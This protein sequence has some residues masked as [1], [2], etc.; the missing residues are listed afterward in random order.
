M[1]N[2]LA[3]DT[4]LTAVADAIRTKGGTSASLAFPAGFVSAIADI[5]TGGGSTEPKQIN[6]VNFFDYDG[7][8]VY[9]Y[10]AA[11]FLA[12]DAL[13]QLPSHTGLTAQGWNWTLADAKTQVQTMGLCD[14]GVN[15]ITSDGKTRLYCRFLDSCLSLYI[16]LGV[17]GT[18][19][20]DWG[21][22][23][24]PSTLTGTS[25]TAVVRTPHVYASAGN[26]VVTITVESGSFAIIGN[27]TASGYSY[28]FN[29]LDA[30]PDRNSMPYLAAVSK[31]ELG[32]NAKIGAG[33]CIKLGIESITIPQGQTGFKCMFSNVYALKH[34]NLPQGFNA[35]SAVNPTTYPYLKTISL[36]RSCTKGLMLDYGYSLVRV[37]LP[38]EA[39]ALGSQMFRN[40]YA[41]REFVIPP[42]ITSIPSY[43]NSSGSLAKLT[44]PASVTS[45][46]TNAFNS[47]TNLQELHFKS[48]TP[49]TAA[50]TNS[51]GLSTKVTIYVPAGTLS[52][53]TS[54]TNYPSAST[55]TYVEE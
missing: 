3:T 13:P 46:A 50:N 44:I 28:L 41:L 4:D 52:D 10:K 48:T 21:D 19:S 39:T 36:P 8:I 53:Y 55:Y 5:P 16:G 12:L 2:Y 32:Q 47:C 7:T 40:S 18:V 37:V 9:N 1:S 26:Y 6:D 38:Y 29:N 25:L 17:N 23:T 11:D 49:P 34:I 15:Y 24:Q 30:A 14:I 43:F 45:L 42:N 31:I 33:G 20:I 51:F 27:D 54:A 22:N 35:A